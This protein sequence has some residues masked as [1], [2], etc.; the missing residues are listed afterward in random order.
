MRSAGGG[1]PGTNL[2]PIQ[3]V[4]A[5]DLND[6]FKISDDKMS[7]V[8]ALRFRIRQLDK[9]PVMKL[10]QIISAIDDELARL[11]QA[12][13]L[14]ANNGT[15]SPGAKPVAKKRKMSAA[16]RA[17]IAAAQKKAWAARKKLGIA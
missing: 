11:Q 14:L 10:D 15:P 8:T 16:T 1:E 7:P 6:A 5:I 9:L 3:P 13:K 4:V 2:S 17:K 12:R